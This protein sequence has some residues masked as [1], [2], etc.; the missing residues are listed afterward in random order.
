MPPSPPAA[1]L[2][3]SGLLKMRNCRDRD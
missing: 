3:E 2:D 1:G